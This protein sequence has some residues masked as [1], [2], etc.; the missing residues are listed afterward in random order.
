MSISGMEN[1]NVAGM[2]WGIKLFWKTLTP[3]VCKKYIDHIH[4]VIP[5]MEKHLDIDN[6]NQV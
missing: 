5:I 2:K 4:K 1:R 6:S 3:E